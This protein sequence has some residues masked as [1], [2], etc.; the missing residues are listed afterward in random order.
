MARRT[1]SQL[2][3]VELAT[4]RL[5]ES[6]DFFVDVLGLT[7]IAQ[8][9]DGIF[10]RAWGDFLP[11]SLQLTAA[12]EAE[13]RRIGW[14]GGSAQDLERVAAELT[15]EGVESDWVDENLGRGR[16]FQF[17]SPGGHAHEIFWDIKPLALPEELRSSLPNRR[18]K[19]APRGVG[20]RTIDHVTVGTDDVMRDVRWFCDKLDFRYMEDTVLDDS[21]DTVIFGMTS[22]T[23]QAHN[24]GI[25]L[26]PAGPPG[27]T[28]HLAYWLDQEPD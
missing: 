15:A 8:T 22:T 6:R 11:Y 3:Y 18:Q 19:F 4:P 23:E 20:A 2:A 12:A 25:I 14:R 16:A 5:Q 28:H 17:R 26:N 24:L 27:A 1:I 7:E 21:P 9:N 13:T 10:L